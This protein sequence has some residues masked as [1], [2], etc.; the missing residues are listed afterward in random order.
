MAGSK[1]LK[2]EILLLVSSIIWGFAFV[3]QRMGMEHVGPFIF[4]G[5]R[6]ALGA[7][8][9][10]PF[11]L[12]SLRREGRTG[13]RTVFASGAAAGVILFLGASLQQIGL[14]YTTAG[15]AGFITGLY[16]VLVPVLGIA[17]GHRTGRD[18]WIGILFAAAGL[19]L[20]SFTGRFSIAGGDLLV[21]AGT[22]FWACHVLLIGSVIGRVNA[23]LLAVIQ[24]YVCSLLSLLV[25]FIFEPVELGG[26]KDAT[27]PILYGGFLSVGIAYTLQLFGQRHAPPSH[28]AIILSLETVFAAIGGWLVLGENIPPRGLLGC[29]LMLFGIIFSQ[30]GLRRSGRR[31]PSVT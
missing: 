5:V 22:F 1:V 23:L 21:L 28:A 18:T 8:A 26:L 19:Y 10:L 6:F 13:G 12:V 16:V 17:T 14:V 27:I 31:P 24:F 25:A 30:Q 7:T 29:A 11:M 3:A 9:L 15:K 20:L 4:N 2:S